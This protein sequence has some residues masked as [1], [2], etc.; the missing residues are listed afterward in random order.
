MEDTRSRLEA[1]REGKEKKAED[2]Y[3]CIGMPAI[4]QKVDLGQSGDDETL[5]V[6]PALPVGVGD[7]WIPFSVLTDSFCS[8]KQHP[9]LV[10]T[11][12]PLPFLLL[13]PTRLLASTPFLMRL[14][15]QFF[16]RCPTS[17]RYTPSSARLVSSTNYC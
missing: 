6:K 12:A 4:L 14:Q 2:R 8:Q 5:R 7:L 16:P 3:S 13:D 15:S 17:T 10:L 11:D 9:S 1:R